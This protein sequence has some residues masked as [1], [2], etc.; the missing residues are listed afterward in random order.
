M[1][2]AI[3]SMKP[4]TDASS[5]EEA[6]RRASVVALQMEHYHSLS[7]EKCWP[8]T[9]GSTVKANKCPPGI[10]TPDIASLEMG[11]SIS[12]EGTFTSVTDG[13]WLVTY[14]TPDAIDANYP[15]NFS[16]L[17]AYYIRTKTWD[18]VHSGVYDASRQ[19]FGY[20]PGGEPLP[21]ASP[22]AG[23]DIPD[24]AVVQETEVDYLY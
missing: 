1:L 2:M 12:Y 14:W 15:V 20:V 8:V 10:V 21:L 17:V 22:F 4:L 23:V 24:G 3:F 9:T 11:Q 7:L 5:E 19:E 16:G 18:T 6:D 13:K